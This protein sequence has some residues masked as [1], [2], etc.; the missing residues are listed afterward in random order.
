MHPFFDETLNNQSIQLLN[1]KL[2]LIHLYSAF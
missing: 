1:L 2:K